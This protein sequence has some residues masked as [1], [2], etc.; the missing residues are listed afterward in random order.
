SAYINYNWVPSGDTVFTRNDA[1]LLV[2]TKTGEQSTTIILGT[3]NGSAIGRLFFNP[4]SETDA[5]QMYINASGSAS[6]VRSSFEPGVFFGQRVVSTDEEIYLDGVHQA[7]GNPDSNGVS[8]H[9]LVGFA[10]NNNGTVSGHRE[11]HLGIV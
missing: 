8:D 2:Y 7:T 4:R 10:F 6:F 11:G 5:A 3:T 1:G 9:S